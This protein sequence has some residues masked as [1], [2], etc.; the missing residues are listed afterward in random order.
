MRIRTDE[1]RL[2]DQADNQTEAVSEIKNGVIVNHS[3]FGMEDPIGGG[4]QCTSKKGYLIENGEKTQLLKGIA[5]SGYV[6]DVLQNIDA[7]SND[8]TKFHGGTCGK[9]HAD[10]VPVTDGGSYIRIKEVLISPG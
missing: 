9:G 6:L 1:E 2:T 10:G 7:V 3:Y 8:A 4:M 5:L